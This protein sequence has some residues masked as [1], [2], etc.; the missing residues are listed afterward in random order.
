MKTLLTLCTAVL[1]LASWNTFAAQTKQDSS[2]S[3]VC[4]EQARTICAKHKKHRKKY[5]FC[6]KEVYSNCMHQLM[7]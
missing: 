1:L 5:D 2:K 7:K 4:M 3:D 6:M